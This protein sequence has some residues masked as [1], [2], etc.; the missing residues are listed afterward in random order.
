MTDDSSRDRMLAALREIRRE[1]W[2]VATVYALVDA[3]L[4]TLAV[5]LL[6]RVTPPP[7]LPAS[8]PVPAGIADAISAT[9]PPPSIETAAIVG[10]AVGALAFAVESA[11]RVRRPLV[12]Q[13][14]AANPEVREALRTAR[15]VAERSPASNRNSSNS[16]NVSDDGEETTMAVALYEDVLG[17]LRNTSSVGL[18]DLRRVAATVLLVTLVSVATVHVAV[19]DLEITGLGSGPNAG[20]DANVERTPDRQY[21]GLNDG[22]SILGDAENVSAGDEELEAE[23]PSQGGGDGD[24]SADAPAAYDSGGFSGEASVEGQAAAFGGDDRAEDAELIREYNLKIRSKDDNSS[25]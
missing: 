4:L 18:I 21:E 15:D 20:P 22:S 25:T 23:L 7:G 5:N 24:A 2:K 10:V 16:G 13:F 14:E 1:G 3:A 17:R 19:V 9:G 11:L 8:V 12:E 6:L